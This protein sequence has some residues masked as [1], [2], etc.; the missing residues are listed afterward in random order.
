M[1]QFFISPLSPFIPFIPVEKTK[2]GFGLQGFC[3]PHHQ[4]I[5]STGMK[6][7]DGDEGDKKEMG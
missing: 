1:S 4:S 7:M 6:G 2:G 5:F 3:A